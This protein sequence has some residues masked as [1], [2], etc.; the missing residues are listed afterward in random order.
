MR[1][2]RQEG[3]IMRE[4]AALIGLATVIGILLFR[5]LVGRGQLPL[6]RMAPGVS[7][8]HDEGASPADRTRRDQARALARAINA[9]EGRAVQSSQRYL[10]LNQLP[11]LPMTPAAFEVRLYTDGIGYLV[12]LKDTI[13]PCRYGLF[14]DQ[15]GLLYEVTPQRP[16]IAS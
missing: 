16:L 13:D 15:L 10:P 12:S 4:R 7:C 9:A 8:R 6:P 11:G 2:A 14:T 5:P 3:R 1:F